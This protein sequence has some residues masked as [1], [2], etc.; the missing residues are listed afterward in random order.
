MF[1]GIYYANKKKSDN[2]FTDAFYGQFCLC[3]R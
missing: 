3:K 2:N 1:I